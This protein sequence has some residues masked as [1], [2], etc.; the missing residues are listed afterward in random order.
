[1]PSSASL[2]SPVNVTALSVVTVVP[3]GGWVMVT[4]DADHGCSRVLGEWYRHAAE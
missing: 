2:A 4:D 1:L 3:F